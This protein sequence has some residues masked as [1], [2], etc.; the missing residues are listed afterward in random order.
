MV[1]L[2]GVAD[3]I[4]AGG[5]P[6]ANAANAVIAGVRGAVLNSTSGTATAAATG[7]SVYWPPYRTLYDVHYDTVPAI[8]VWRTLLSAIQDATATASA[9][10]FVSSVPSM[11]SAGGNI[12]L[13]GNLVAGSQISVVSEGMYYGL[14]IDTRYFVLG[15]TYGGLSGSTVSASWNKSAMVVSQGAKSD[16]TYFSYQ[17]GESGTFVVTLPFGYATNASDTSLDTALLVQVYDSTGTLTQ[18]TLYLSTAAGYGELT[19]APGSLLSPVYAELV[20]GGMVW[21]ATGTVFDANTTISF[22]LQALS[23]TATNTTAFG[24]LYADDYAGNTAEAMW[25]GEL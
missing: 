20:S 17:P 16:Y 10:K 12:T 19:P 4:A 9:P 3:I 24:V 2:G 13:S 6:V 22:A 1:D 18:Q 15:D 25:E 11:S 5:G 14:H 21:G 7:I 8:A 23:T